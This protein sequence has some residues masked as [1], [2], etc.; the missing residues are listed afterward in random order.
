MKVLTI[1]AASSISSHVVAQV[2]GRSFNAQ[3]SPRDVPE[4][5]W[6]YG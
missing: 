1:I 6:G 2:C 3:V 5:N 4:L